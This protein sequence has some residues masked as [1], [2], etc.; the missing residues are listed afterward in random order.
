MF[1]GTGTDGHVLVPATL[2]SFAGRFVWKGS[3]E[4]ACVVCDGVPRTN[5]V[6]WRGMRG[7]ATSAS[8][9]EQSREGDR[10]EVPCSCGAPTCDVLV[11]P[12]RTVVQSSNQ[13]V[14]SLHREETPRGSDPSSVPPGSC[15][16]RYVVGDDIDGYLR[17]D[18]YH[19]RGGYRQPDGF[20]TIDIR[21]PG[22]FHT[23]V[24]EDE[25]CATRRRST[26]TRAT[27]A[28]ETVRNERSGVVPGREE[29][30]IQNPDP[31][32]V[33]EPDVERRWCWKPR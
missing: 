1:G 33:V 27:K 11:D 7:T 14:L 17:V 9:D 25:R 18:R 26:R 20:N 3:V 10:S 15:S 13:S 23:C 22:P 6:G 5:D 24:D 8:V 2:P 32:D 12:F 30:Q 28:K 16:H 4:L 31:T 21:G 19:S 29:K